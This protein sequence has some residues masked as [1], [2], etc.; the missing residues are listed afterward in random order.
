MVTGQ[1]GRS[2]LILRPLSREEINETVFSGG[3]RLV[4][5]GSLPISRGVRYVATL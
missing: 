5:K 4:P 3:Q 1:R 2:V